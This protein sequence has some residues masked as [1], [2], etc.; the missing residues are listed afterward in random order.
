Q[1]EVA[2]DDPWGAETLEW[3]TTSPPPSYNYAYLPTVRSR[4]PLWDPSPRP[5]VTGL[6]TDKREVLVT[7]ALDA[8]PDHRYEQPGHSI[9][10]F[11]LVI[12]T[13]AGIC[14]ALFT[15]WGVILGAVLTF[16]AL[17]GWFWGNEALGV[18]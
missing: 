12:A 4:D 1:G 9:W 14:V 5:V 11:A 17:L 16:F 2:G 18:E 7:T 3:Q 15:P 13:T 8:E 6:R 10:P